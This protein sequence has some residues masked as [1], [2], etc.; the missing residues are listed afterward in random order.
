MRATGITAETW[1]ARAELALAAFIR[2]YLHNEPPPDGSAIADDLRVYAERLEHHGEQQL[3]A[4]G[5]RRL[6]AGA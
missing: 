4:V 6:K 1:D 3:L 5:A 2:T